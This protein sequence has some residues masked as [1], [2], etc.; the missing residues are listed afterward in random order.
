M[1]RQLQEVEK[2]KKER[3]WRR[4][5][6][7]TQGDMGYVKKTAGFIHLF[8][9]LTQRDIDVIGTIHTFNET[10]GGVFPGRCGVC[11]MGSMGVV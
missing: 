7:F 4:F 5:S 10:V 2:A 1:G 6:L 3:V 9:P 8:D 11:G